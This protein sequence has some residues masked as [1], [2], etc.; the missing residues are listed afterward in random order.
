MPTNPLVC[1]FPLDYLP[2][3]Y[4]ALFIFFCLFA[5]QSLTAMFK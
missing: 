1:E 3:I 2:L 4:K 5:W